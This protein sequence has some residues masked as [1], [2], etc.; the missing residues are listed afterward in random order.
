MKFLY[1]RVQKLSYSLKKTDRQT[2]R[3]KDT[4]GKTDL[5]EIITCPHL[6]NE[7]FRLFSDLVN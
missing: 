6:R 5:K 1:L 3:N 2:D 7:I 4:D